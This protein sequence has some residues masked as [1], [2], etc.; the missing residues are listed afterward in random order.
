MNAI[1]KQFVD[2]LAAVMEEDRRRTRQ[3]ITEAEERGAVGLSQGLTTV[4]AQIAAIREETAENVAKV[5][6]NEIDRWSKETELAAREVAVRGMEAIAAFEARSA[7]LVEAVT[8]AMEDYERRVPLEW[9]G[10]KK[11]DP[12]EKGDKG[13]PGD[14]G[15]RGEKGDKGDPGEKGDMGEPGIHGLQGE[16]GDKG[17]PGDKGETG[18]RGEPGE[19]GERGEPGERGEQ[20]EQGIP[21]DQGE[22]GERG[23]QGPRGEPG[24]RGA[25]GERGNP[26]ADG[27]CVENRGVWIKDA[28]YVVGN[29][30]SRNG[31][32]W[33][34]DNPTYEEPGKSDDWSLV[35]QRGPKGEKGDQGGRGETGP[36]GPKGDKGER[37]AAAPIIIDVR[38]DGLQLVVVYDDG[39]LTRTDIS[40][41]LLD[42][43]RSVLD[44]IKAE[45]DE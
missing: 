44:M 3:A 8:D 14:Q 38:V 1:P 18:E 31:S 4:M 2:D 37:G 33:L 27:T 34:C 40:P 41:L 28:R 35:A 15:E 45:R 5:V 24:E 10:T 12:G 20:G 26:G 36:T 30:V 6:K 16:K 25:P 32:M 39:D 19:R 17:D 21:G 42:I 9:E 23:E 43:K 22:P 7:A 29:L 11:G 13:D